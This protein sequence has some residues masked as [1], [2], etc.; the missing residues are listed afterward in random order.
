M[1][2]ECPYCDA[3]MDVTRLSRH[4]RLAADDVHG[5]YGSVPDAGFDNPWNLRLEFSE[6]G[7]ETAEGSPDVDAIRTRVRRGRCPSC[8]LGVLGQKGGDGFLSRGRRRLACPNCGWESP[9]W[10]EIE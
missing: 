4:V 6:T 3:R 7:Q 8:D 10:I 9:E 2:T 5:P 1:E